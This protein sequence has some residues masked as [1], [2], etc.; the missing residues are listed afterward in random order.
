MSESSI[1]GAVVV[2]QKIEPG[3]MVP[4]VRYMVTPKGG[5]GTARVLSIINDMGPETPD[6]LIAAA[7]EMDAIMRQTTRKNHGDDVVISFSPKR[8]NPS[9]PA[10]VA[11]AREIVAETLRRVVPDTPHLAVLQGD[12]GV[13]HAHLAVPNHIVQTGK[14][15]RTGWH[16]Q[17]WRDVNDQVL[18]EHGIEPIVPG[19]SARSEVERVAAARGLLVPDHDALIAMEPSTIT[20]RE[21]DSFLAAHIGEAIID[22]RLSAV[23]GPGEAVSVP[24]DDDTAL[25]VRC[26]TRGGLSYAVTDSDGVP[27]RTA[28]GKRGGKPT[29][30]A[31][32]AG[33]L[34]RA[35]HTEA[36][37][38]DALYGSLWLADQIAAMSAEQEQEKEDDREAVER[39]REAEA[40][41]AAARAEAD[42]AAAAAERDGVPL[43]D[44]AE[45]I[46]ERTSG[47]SGLGVDHRPVG[48]SA[49]QGDR[50][51]PLEVVGE[52]AGTAVLGSG[53]AD[54]D[55]PGGGREAGSVS[56]HRGGPGGVEPVAVRRVANAK[57]AVALM[58][59]AAIEGAAD[60]AEPTTSVV[61]ATGP[62]VVGNH[63]RTREERQHG[64]K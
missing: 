45:R 58:H 7:V 24:I 47:R 64:D 55:G 4:Y 46:G 16:H 20:P 11:E 6:G 9:N 25:S 31:R 52:S 1:D 27:V 28:P 49:E 3:R 13:L 26:G 34:D 39:R 8:F 54:G 41:E 18:R 57:R 2:T 50:S 35:H 15:R 14:A 48:A 5:D 32:S 12:N 56:W 53:G 17:E 30:I 19:R 36:D 33:K 59:A 29:P 22:G 23:P 62:T 38:R 40:L 44:D 51:Q 61:A 43:G 60:G 10:H 63:G 21:L 42:R 37:G